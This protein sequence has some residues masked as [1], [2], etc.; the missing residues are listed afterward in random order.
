MSLHIVTTGRQQLPE[1]MR[2]LER[3]HPYAD[4]IHLREKA[5]TAATYWAAVESLVSAGVPLEKLILHDRADVAYAAGAGGVQLTWQSMPLSACRAVFPNMRIGCSVHSSEEAAARTAEGADYLLYGHVFATASKKDVPPR[6]VSGLRK[7]CETAGIPVVAIGGMT[8]ENTGAVIDAGAA[9]I[10]V[11]S[12][13]FSHTDP[14]QA[15]RL[16]R[17][18][19]TQAGCDK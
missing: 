9:G 13:V 15:M 12:G 14:L 7:T 19:L 17:E 6:G 16:Y 5:W 8:P 1:L 3:I 18:A 2:I 4:R 11:M 10:A